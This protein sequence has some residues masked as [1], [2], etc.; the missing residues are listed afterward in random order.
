MTDKKTLIRVRNLSCSF[1]NGT[2]AL[3]GVNLEIYEK[4][5]LIVSGPNGSGKS[6]L[7]K[8]LNGLIKPTD[9]EI[10]FKDESIHKNLNKTRQMI[11]LVFQ[12]ADS[13]IIGQTVERDVA[14]GPENLQ[15]KRE[16]ISHRVEQALIAVD[17]LDKKDDRPHVLSGGEKRRLAVAGILAMEPQILIF[18]EPFSNL[19]YGGVQNVL[20]QIVQ[21]HRKGHTV[22][23]ITHDLGKIL[24]HGERL[25][26]MN[27]GKIVEQG[28][29][30]DLL[31]K[32]E[33]WGIRRPHEENYRD[34]T[35]LK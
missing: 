15:L 13:Q 31:E 21:L 2:V 26:I 20:K 35:W 24:A 19:D 17:L 34:M 8:H 5:F 32:L 25:I 3:D 28:Q 16:E 1:S 33:L 30:E 23:V 6:V 12:D 9:G 7:M 14:F 4:E 18:D 29:P 11:G 27:K 10:T 22:V